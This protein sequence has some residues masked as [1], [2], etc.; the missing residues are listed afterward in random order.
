MRFYDQE[1]GRIALL[2]RIS[3]IVLLVVSRAF[4]VFGAF[5]RR[6][7]CRLRLIVV[8][9]ILRRRRGRARFWLPSHASVLVCKSSGFGA[10]FRRGVYD[11]LSE[12]VASRRR[13]DSF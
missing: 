12:D 1:K 8:S 5:R 13:E 11:L 7:A 9:R 10:R 3:A 6:G 2:G 4:S